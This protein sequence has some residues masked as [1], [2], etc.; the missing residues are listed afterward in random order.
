MMM[1]PEC[2]IEELRDK[3]LSELIKERNE[4]IKGIE[5]L[6][7]IVFESPKVSEEWNTCP[8]PN[9]K[10]SWC[11][12]YLAKLCELIREKYTEQNWN[13]EKFEVIRKNIFYYSVGRYE[14]FTSDA[15]I[16]VFEEEGKYYAEYMIPDEDGS[17]KEVEIEI[18]EETIAKIRDVISQNSKILKMQYSERPPVSNGY[19]DEFVFADGET[20]NTIYACNLWYYEEKKEEASEDSMFLLDTF[21]KIRNI[22]IEAGV[23]EAC[24]KLR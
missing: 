19:I 7:K 14:G 2:L 3:N 24:L 12:E 4:L 9:V 13:N 1:P 23:D 22:L 17:P 11:H 5:N 6:E 18:R 16:K 15:W 10:Y 20:V 8:G 21:K